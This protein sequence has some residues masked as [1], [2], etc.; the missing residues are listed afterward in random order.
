VERER[1]RSA[2]LA[3]GWDIPQAQGNFV[4]LPLGEDTVEFAALAAE[5]GVMVRPFAGDGA[6]V[7]IGEAAGNDVL[8]RVAADW[9][10]RT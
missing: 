4:W 3:D 5:A 7:S 1:V 2:L 10:R 6:R 9:R 8:L